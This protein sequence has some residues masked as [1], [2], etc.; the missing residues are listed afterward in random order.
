M[1]CREIRRL[2]AAAALGAL[3]GAELEQS[4]HHLAACPTCHA[5]FGR[6]RRALDLAA[7]GT[8]APVP[9]TLAPRV[10]AAGR[11][12]LA[13]EG[14][15][16]GRRLWAAWLAASAAAL[17]LAAG[18]VWQAGRPRPA[19]PCG[20]WRFVDGDPG[21]AR[22][23]ESPAGLVPE[24]VAWERSVAGA[25]GAY[26]P[27][28]WKDLV[29][30][31]AEPERRTHR[32]GGRLLA[33]DSA[34][35]AVR[36]TRD[37][38]AGDFYKAKGFPDR[39]IVDGRLYLT[40]GESCLVLDAATGRELA[41]FEPPESA[42]GWSYLAAA[43]GSL[44]GAARDGRTVFC[45]EAAGGRPVWSRPVEPGVFVPALA[46]GKL[47]CAT[48]AGALAALDAATGAELWRR[49]AVL[50]PGKASV[51][52]RGALVLVLAGNDELAAFGS[53]DG[54]P[55]W[56]RAMRGA[57]ASGLAFGDEAVYLLGGSAALALADGAVLWQQAEPAGSVCAAPTA[58]GG[59]VLAPAGAAPGSLITLDR[60][61][62]S[63]GALSEAAR[64]SCDGAIV[65]GGRIFTVADGKLL[66]VAC[67]AGG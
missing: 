18:W 46:G 41:R 53:A 38:P 36:W 16:R 65:A 12:E 13:A 7:A 33:F 50:P 57:F 15:R 32:G 61:G 2:A 49:E 1:D 21:N 5:E 43:G 31:G 63:L 40:D 58:A 52:A 28:A 45:V 56:K 51:H 59:G 64:R 55:A 66:A 17:L 29:I 24:R 9:E 11:A 19:A 8:S 14:R 39:C 4:Q 54:R 62:R 34:G 20:C 44:Y 27:L 26:K 25:P 35:G 47:Y 6:N 22:R 67:R 48:G 42:R 37:F 60:A 3:E 10:A 30:V 23:S